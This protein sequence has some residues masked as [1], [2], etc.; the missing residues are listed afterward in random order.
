MNEGVQALGK[1]RTYTY[2][3]FVFDV[4]L[5]GHAAIANLFKVQDSKILYGLIALIVLQA[6]VGSMYVVKYASEAENIINI[7]YGMKGKGKNKKA[8]A[9]KAS[10][11]RDKALGK[12]MMYASRARFIIMGHYVVILLLL[13]NNLQIHSYIFDKAVVASTLVLIYFTLKYITILQRGRF[14]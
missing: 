14:E 8:K 11:E 9:T 5:F 1:A 6:T 7:T 10:A 3:L 13:L 12:A 2:M 4:L